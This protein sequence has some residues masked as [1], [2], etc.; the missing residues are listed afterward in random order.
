MHPVY[1]LPMNFNVSDLPP[2]GTRVPVE[3]LTDVSQD[4]LSAAKVMGARAVQLGVI[5]STSAVRCDLELYTS[6]NDG[7]V[8]VK[9]WEGVDYT[10]QDGLYA[11]NLEHV[12]L[13][14]LPLKIKAKNI[15][16][17][18]VTVRAVMVV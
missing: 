5:F 3:F 7:D 2:S 6:G 9:S 15:S 16:G 18:S 8:L 13:A 1:G 17:G 12:D 14:C 11:G 10:N 4:T